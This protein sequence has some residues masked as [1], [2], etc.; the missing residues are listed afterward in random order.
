MHPRK[1][2]GEAD[3]RLNPH[4][5]EEAN[6][7]DEQKRRLSGHMPRAN[8]EM[9]TAGSTDQAA[10]GLSLSDPPKNAAPAAVGSSGAA[11]GNPMKL[12]SRM[13][14]QNSFTRSLEGFMAGSGQ[15]A[16]GGIEKT[17]L[18]IVMDES[19]CDQFRKFLEVRYM[20]EGLKCLLE[21]LEFEMEPSVH[22]GKQ[23]FDKYFASGAAE[24]VTVGLELAESLAVQLAAQRVPDFMGVKCE[25]RNESEKRELGSDPLFLPD[26]D[27]A[28]D[29]A[30]RVC[31]G[32][33]LADRGVV[34]SRGARL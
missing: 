27:V 4:D 17:L 33:L 1:D 6:A 23:L 18:A 8:A 5:K 11:P 22:G 12:Y 31:G 29:G 25:V 28:L 30:C 19:K 16:K 26:S 2:K 32:V 21:I 20:D 7:G 3:S 9:T 34:L 13:Q 10:R 24:E 14:R 15:F